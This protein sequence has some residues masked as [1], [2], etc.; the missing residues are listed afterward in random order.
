MGNV[1]SDVSLWIFWTYYRTWHSCSQWPELQHGNWT[2][3]SIFSRDLKHSALAIQP[4]ILTKNR[5]NGK[6][7]N[8]RCNNAVTRQK[9]HIWAVKTRV[10]IIYL[11]VKLNKTQKDYWTQT[12]VFLTGVKLKKIIS[13]FRRL[14]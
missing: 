13:Y 5:N 11:Q 10:T 7:I 9:N 3:A 4:Q 2:H 14:N 8:R 6:Y 1:L 12:L